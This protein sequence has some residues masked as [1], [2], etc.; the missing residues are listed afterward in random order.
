MNGR[1]PKPLDPIAIALTAGPTDAEGRLRRAIL[2]TI[3]A[4]AGPMTFTQVCREMPA[5]AWEDYSFGRFGETLDALVRDGLLV[6]AD[7][8]ELKCWDLA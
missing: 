6:R 8:P 2:R 4:H 7:L 1:H 3:G 5:G